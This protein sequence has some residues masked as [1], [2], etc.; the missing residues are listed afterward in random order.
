[1]AI[2]HLLATYSGAREA[3]GSSFDP[4]RSGVGGLAHLT[5]MNT[6]ASTRVSNSHAS[7]IETTHGGI[8][9]VLTLAEIAAH[10]GVSVQ[11][12][13]DLRNKGRGPR[14]FKVGRHLHFRIS[15][16]EAWLRQLESTDSCPAAAPPDN[17]PSSTVTGPLTVV[18]DQPPEPATPAVKPAEERPME[19][20]QELAGDQW[21]LR[22]D[23]PRR[24]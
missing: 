14:G 21:A 3:C 2:V 17:R 22:L 11:A 7:R 9:P 20:G 12:L 6:T 16:V 23:V 19:S 15:E 5:G 13:Y 1:M 18:P 4:S 10:L 8:E 24:S